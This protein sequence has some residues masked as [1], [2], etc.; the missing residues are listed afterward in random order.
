MRVIAGQFKGRILVGPRGKIIRPTSDRIKEFIFDYLGGIVQNIN[1]LELFAGT[2][3]LSIEAISRGAQ[4]ATLVD[5]ADEAI[6]IIYKNVELTNSSAKCYIIKKEA[7]RFLELA[8]KRSL[9]FGL[10]FADPPYSEMIY[11]NILER[12]D[13]SDILEKRGLFILEHSSTKL[14]HADYKHLLP[15]KK[16]KFGNTTITIFEKW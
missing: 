1:L 12:I 14:I 6:E 5:S 8:K 16:K 10:I 9:N 15:I 3:N 4:K 2:G 13:D 7:L 11:H